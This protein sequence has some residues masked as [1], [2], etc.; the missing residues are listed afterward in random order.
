MPEQESLNRPSWLPGF[1]NRLADPAIDTV[2]LCGCGGGF[3]FVHGMIL[4]PELQRLGKKVIIGSYSFGRPEE[5]GEPAETV[6]SQSGA[7]VKQVTGKSQPKPSYGPEVH[8]CRFLDSRFPQEAPHFIYAYYARV[9]TV[10]LLSRF[11][12]QLVEA[13]RIDAI[14]L[15]DG[16]SDSLMA[17]D[18]EGLGDPIEDAVSVAAVAG[19]EPLKEKLLITIGFGADRF[20]QVSDAAS[21][22]AVAELTRL[23]GYLGALGL[24]PESAGFQF[25]RSALD[26]IQAGQGPGGFRSV[27]AGAILA[28]GEGAFGSG[29]VPARLQPRVGPGEMFLWP[30]MA[31]LWGFDVDRVAERSLICDWIK[32]CATIPECQAALWEGRSRLGKGIRGVENLPRHE[33]MRYEG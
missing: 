32:G 29:Q 28:A 23:G 14:V 24:D 2:L 26:Y 33:E 25:Y 3:D 8:L 5:I 13:H 4:Y 15:V 1:L 12:R 30:L 19:L 11:Y 7:V 17:G 20:N 27:I 10:P 18:E 16:G 21:L 22:R 31:M 6:F 9:F